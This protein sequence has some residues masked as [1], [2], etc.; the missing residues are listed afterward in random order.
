MS[1]FSSELSLVLLTGQENPQRI[2]QSCSAEGQW[3]GRSLPDI[4][5]ARNHA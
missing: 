1:L 4:P 5:M 2:H 3:K